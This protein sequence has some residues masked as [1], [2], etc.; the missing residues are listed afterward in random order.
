MHRTCHY[1]TYYN[2]INSGAKFQHFTSLTH[3]VGPLRQRWLL[4]SVNLHLS[5]ISVFS[6]AF[7]IETCT[8]FHIPQFT[9]TSWL[10]QQ[11][12]FKCSFWRQEPQTAQSK[13]MFTLFFFFY[14]AQACSTLCDP[15][16]CGLP[17]SSIHGIFQTR[18]PQ[19]LAISFSG[20]SSWP[21][22]RTCISCVSWIAGRF[23]I[24][25]ATGEAHAYT[26]ATEND[27]SHST[28]KHHA[29]RLR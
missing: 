2:T 6:G 3:N 13:T 11:D 19:W 12:S 28:A 25:W 26:K 1:P 17:G 29:H 4:T 8:T 15:L 24:Y 9:A 21:R 23:F 20:G 16:D 14:V 10:K 5:S 22:D 7:H 18:I 27:W